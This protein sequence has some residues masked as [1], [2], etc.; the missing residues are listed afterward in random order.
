MFLKTFETHSILV[1]SESERK[2][3][4]RI[5]ERGLNTHPE[6][7]IRDKWTDLI[8]GREIAKTSAAD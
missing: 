1:L 6:P 8:Q 3:W 5:M 2:E 4:Q 7:P